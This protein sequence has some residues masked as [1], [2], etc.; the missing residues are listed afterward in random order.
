VLLND[1]IARR[2]DEVAGLLNEQDASPFR[3]QAYRRAAATVRHLPTP[4]SELFEHQGIDGLRKL[5]G[6]GDHLATAIRIL[7]VTGRL[8]ILERLRGEADP[9]ELLMSVPGIGQVQAF[10]L[11]HDLGIDTLEE[12]EA[13]ANDGRLEEVAGLGPKT[14]AGI[15]DSLAT[16]LG[17][18]REPAP[19]APDEVPVS[20][21]LD[22]DREYRELAEA[23][24][25]RR[26]TPRRFNP[27]REPWLPVLHTFRGARQYTAMFSNTARAHKLGKTHDWVILYHDSKGGD[28][29]YTVITGHQGALKG[30]RIVRG[31][32]AECE[33][34]YSGLQR[35][36]SRPAVAV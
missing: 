22:V 10:R 29:Q 18:V 33:Q 12:L 11:H 26:I 28:R 16:R 36:A 20:E 30:K 14:V 19:A 27:A 32:E 5:P 21:L 25:L 3:V 35:D 6:I 34:L 23:G 1:Q 17:R 24:K 8:P 31:R 15:I 4:V 2:L 7:L 13:A 9:I